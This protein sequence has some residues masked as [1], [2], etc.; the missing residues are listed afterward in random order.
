MLTELQV[1]EYVAYFTV[2]VQVSQADNRDERAKEIVDRYLFSG[3]VVDVELSED[4]E[5]FLVQVRVEGDQCASLSRRVTANR[6]RL[7][8]GLYPS[9]QPAFLTRFGDRDRRD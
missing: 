9:T 3:E 7:M 6:D 1:P 8:S 2:G 5:T 4:Y